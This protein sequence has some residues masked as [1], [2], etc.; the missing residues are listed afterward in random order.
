VIPRAAIPTVAFVA[1]PISFMGWFVLKDEWRVFCFL[2]CFL[3]GI[4]FSPA[5]YNNGYGLYVG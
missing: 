2:L 4:K 3:H 5:F 1:S